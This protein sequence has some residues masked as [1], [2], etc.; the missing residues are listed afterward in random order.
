MKNISKHI[1]IQ[2]YVD[3]NVGGK[4][5]QVLWHDSVFPSHSA[6][7]RTPEFQLSHEP[8]IGRLHF[9]TCTSFKQVQHIEICVHTLC[10]H[11]DIQVYYWIIS[12]MI[13]HDPHS[14]TL[15]WISNIHSLT[16]RIPTNKTGSKLGDIMRVRA[17]PYDLK[18]AFFFCRFWEPWISIRLPSGN[19]T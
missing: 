4:E 15:N 12:I 14:T 16:I 1:N 13:I 18:A 8:E 10:W 6:V 5:L 19:L 2:W 7:E 17:P 11:I 9:S 3:I